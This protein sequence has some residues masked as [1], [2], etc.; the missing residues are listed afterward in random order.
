MPIT[1]QTIVICWHLSIGRSILSRAMPTARQQAKLDHDFTVGTRFEDVVNGCQQGFEVCVIPVI[2]RGVKIT[3][4]F[5]QNEVL[6][7]YFGDLVSLKE[8]DRREAAGPEIGH[9]YRYKFRVGTK[10]YVLDAT[11]EDGTL[12]RLLNHSRKQPNVRPKPVLIDGEPAIIFVAMFDLEVGT[13][14]RYDYGERK[15]EV[16]EKN[17]WLKK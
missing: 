11:R 1:V 5:K 7:R 13:E 4:R 9:F 16:I 17:P 14:L 6:L 15:K 12:G 3:R 10:S 2:G 8:A